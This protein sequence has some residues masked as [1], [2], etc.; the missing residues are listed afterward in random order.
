M[1]VR[2]KASKEERKESKEWRDETTKKGKS[3]KVKE[4]DRILC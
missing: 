1:Y 2:I 3:G 4:G